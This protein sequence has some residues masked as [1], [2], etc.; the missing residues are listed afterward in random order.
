[1]SLSDYKFSSGDSAP[2]T[3]PPLAT[4]I[5]SI[6]AHHPHTYHHHVP[7]HLGAINTFIQNNAALVGCKCFCV[8][9]GGGLLSF[10]R[11]QRAEEKCFSC[12]LFFFFFFSNHKTLPRLDHTHILLRFLR[13]AKVAPACVQS[14]ETSQTQNKT[15]KVQMRGF[16]W[17]CQS[18]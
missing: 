3:P 15:T 1:M 9:G 8:C 6:T 17:D 10:F 18:D 2:P 5:V 14:L 11:K 16:F 13:W 4:L 12:L 7:I